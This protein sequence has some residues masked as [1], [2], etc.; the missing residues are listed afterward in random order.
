MIKILGKITITMGEKKDR[1]LLS[2]VLG[3][4]V[5]EVKCS[6]LKIWSSQKQW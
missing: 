2:A 4:S 6:W 5:Y 3:L 1:G